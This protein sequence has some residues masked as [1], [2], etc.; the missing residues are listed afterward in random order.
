MYPEIAV[1]PL[2]ALNVT[3]L[4]AKEAYVPTT[5]MKNETEQDRFFCPGKILSRLI[6]GRSERVRYALHAEELR[7][8]VASNH[9]IPEEKRRAIQKNYDMMT[10][11]LLRVEI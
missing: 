6:T 1:E 9:R 5:N 8:A 4:V 3:T 11:E 2:A 10:A 7:L